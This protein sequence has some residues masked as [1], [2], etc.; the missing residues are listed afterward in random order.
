MKQ[1]KTPVGSSIRGEPVLRIE[2]SDSVDLA[3]LMRGSVIAPRRF[4]RKS[5]QGRVSMKGIQTFSDLVD[6]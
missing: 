1:E 5:S 2:E 6:L 3:R 4:K